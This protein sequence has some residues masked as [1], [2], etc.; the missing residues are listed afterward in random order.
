MKNDKK[1][2]MGIG[3]GYPSPSPTQ[4]CTLQLGEESPTRYCKSNRIY[5]CSNIFDGR[6]VQ[7]PLCPFLWRKE[8]TFAICVL[9]LPLWSYCSPARRRVEGNKTIIK[10]KINYSYIKEKPYLTLLSLTPFLVSC[11]GIII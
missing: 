11:Y 1:N 10:L 7:L 9:W 2:K 5:T 8:G 6:N 4:S 3:V